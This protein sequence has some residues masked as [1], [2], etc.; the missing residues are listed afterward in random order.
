MRDSIHDRTF[1]PIR[2]A[3]SCGTLRA[4]SPG[5]GRT[6]AQGMMSM[7]FVRL[8]CPYA[9]AVLPAG[10]PMETFNQIE[11]PTAPSPPFLTV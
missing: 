4:G 9:L 2:P 8:V 5:P 3:L 7:G 10:K 6:P 1:S 11:P